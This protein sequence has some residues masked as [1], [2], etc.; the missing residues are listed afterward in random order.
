MNCGGPA[1]GAGGVGLEDMG[2]RVLGTEELVVDADG[3]FDDGIGLFGLS[4]RGALRPDPMSPA[5]PAEFLSAVIRPRR[6]RW[7]ARRSVIA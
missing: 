6:R 4:V 2:E 7:K 1:N 3:L 5:G